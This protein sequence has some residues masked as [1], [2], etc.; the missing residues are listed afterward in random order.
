MEEGESSSRFLRLEKKAGAESWISAMRCSDGTV[1]SDI[2]SICSSWVDFY[3]ELFTA[4][5]IY[6]WAQQDLL[7]NVSARLPEDARDSCEGLLTVDEVFT[8]L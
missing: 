1:A 7:V 2:S 3:S 8:A 5:E 4:S 6:L